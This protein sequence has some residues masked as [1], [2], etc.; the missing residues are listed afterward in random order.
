MFLLV[1][2]HRDPVRRIAGGTASLLFSCAIRLRVKGG[3]LSTP[4]QESL[5]ALQP[6][7]LA[8][9]T[10]SR[11]GI[12]AAAEPRSRAGTQGHKASRQARK[13]NGHHGP[14]LAALPRRHEWAPPR[15]IAT[16]SLKDK[17]LTCPHKSHDPITRLLQSR[18]DNVTSLSISWT[19]ACTPRGPREHLASR[20]LTGPRATHLLALTTAS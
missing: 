10:A 2:V 18:S 3:L 11:P 12:P 17:L 16:S 13:G 8:L 20:A 5:L 14:Y 15:R 1:P 19:A 6:S 7:P 4:R 9:T